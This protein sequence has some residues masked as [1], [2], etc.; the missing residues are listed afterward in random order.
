M[1]E[2]LTAQETEALETYRAYVAQREKIQAGEAGWDTLGEYFTDD[3]V[4]IDP[5]WGRV[6]GIDAVREFLEESMVGLDDW[7]FPERWT[8]VDGDRVVTMFEQL[9]PGADGET[10]QQAGISVLYYAGD[11]KFSYE[12]DLMNMGHIN[13]DL[14]A[15]QWA[16]KGDFNMPPRVPTR[17]Y[18]RPG[19]EAL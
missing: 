17:S 19:G 11:G 5:A 12:M 9:I 10:Y 18:A 1:P 16:P 14:K 8:M 13:Q 4:F 15:A 7:S 3:A 2:K 6:E